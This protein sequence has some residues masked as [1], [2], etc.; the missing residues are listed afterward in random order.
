MSRL[1]ADPVAALV[2]LIAGII[3]G[4]GM[5]VTDDHTSYRPPNLGPPRAEAHNVKSVTSYRPKFGNSE[6]ANFYSASGCGVER[7]AVKT[8]TDPAANQVNLVAQPTTVADLV[9]ITPPINPTDR[10]GPTEATTFV[11][12]G[13]LT[14][15]KKEADGDFH[16]VIQDTAGNSMIVES[17]N[18]SCAVGSVVLPQ[19]TAVRTAV[20]GRLGNGET[21]ST[22]SIPVTVTGVGFFDRLHGQTGV[23][24]NGIELHPLTGIT[25]TGPGA[26]HVSVP[27]L[28]LTDNPKSD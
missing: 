19:I 27:D 18:P 22:V 6:P 13:T 2:T 17:P 26:A 16:M 10:V 11:L 3:I 24:P 23:A 8:L 28:H 5:P 21:P 14:F 1:V 9:S 7:W 20:E 4:V 25:F 15:F 12:S